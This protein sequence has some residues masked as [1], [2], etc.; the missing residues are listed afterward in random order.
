MQS[1]G[2]G[3]ETVGRG[4]SARLD[5]TGTDGWGLGICIEGGGALGSG[6]GVGSG[7]EGFGAGLEGGGG[8][9]QPLLVLGVSVVSVVTRTKKMNTWAR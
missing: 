6:A 7:G 3:A 4:A 9:E 1:E 8:P 5:G 2:P